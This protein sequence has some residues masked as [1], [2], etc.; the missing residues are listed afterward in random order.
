MPSSARVLKTFCTTRE[1]ALLLGISLRTAQLWTESGLLEAW[2]T[3]GGHRR[4]LRKSVERLLAKPDTPA[5]FGK[6]RALTGVPAGK[7]P[8]ERPGVFRLLIVAAD[9]TA[10]SEALPRYTRAVS[11]WPMPTQLNIVAEV[12]E[13]LVRTGLWRPDLLVID[14]QI[15]GIDSGQILRTLRA[16]DELAALRVVVVGD[17]DAAGVAPPGDLPTDAVHWPKPLSLERLR[18][19]AEAVWAVRSVAH[20]AG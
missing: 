18:V 9:A 16:I 19:L 11:D 7:S 6:R 1:A 13:A 4:I 12:G 8:V 17:P 15:S 5:R 2:K 10:R 3:N 20:A 14:A